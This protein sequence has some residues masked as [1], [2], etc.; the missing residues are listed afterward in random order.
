MTKL[1]PR[2]KR[3]AKAKFKV[4]PVHTRMH[5]PAKFVQVRSKILLE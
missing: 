3:A 4:I 1:C 2:G 5:T